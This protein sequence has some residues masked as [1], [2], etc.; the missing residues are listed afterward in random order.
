VGEGSSSVEIADELH[1]SIS[2]VRKH[3]Q[4]AL[5]GLEARSQAEAVALAIRRRLI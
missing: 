5:S 3:I 4:N 2:T 1:I